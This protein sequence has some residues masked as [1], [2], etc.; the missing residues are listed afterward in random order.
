[1]VPTP[2]ADLPE[3]VV[4]ISF[5]VRHMNFI[6]ESGAMYQIGQP[7]TPTQAMGEMLKMGSKSGDLSPHKYEDQ[8]K[9]KHVVANDFHTAALCEDNRVYTWGWGGNT[10][11]GVSA[12]G[13][14]TEGDVNEPKL[15]EALA[16]TPIKQLTAGKYHTLVLTGKSCWIVLFFIMFIIYC[17]CCCCCCCSCSLGPRLE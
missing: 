1:M 7:G 4:D 11:N 3:K 14:P 6:G 5:G 10:I 2:L 17:C 16:D 8:P 13:H 12:L 15:V 9:F